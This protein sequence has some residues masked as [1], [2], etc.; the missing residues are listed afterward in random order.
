MGRNAVNGRRQPVAGA[1]EHLVDTVQ[2]LVA[3]ELHARQAGRRAEHDVA[4]GGIQVA[5][6]CRHINEHAIRV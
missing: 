5:S 6:Q 1:A 2:E 3:A 4:A